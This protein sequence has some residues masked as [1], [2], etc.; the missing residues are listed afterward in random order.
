MLLSVVLPVRNGATYI[1][2]SITSILAQT[3]AEFE[4]IVV[5][6]A[7]TDTTVSIV[8]SFRDRRIRLIREPR[9]GG[10]SAFNSGV[11]VARGRY[12][13][14][15]DAD[16]V[17]S[18]TRFARQLRYLDSRKELGILGGQALRIDESGSIV[19]R[20][21]VPLTTGA[22]RL[23]SHY[24][25]PMVHPTIVF[26]RDVWTK[27]GG[28]REFAPA[29]DYDF[30]L[31]ALEHSVPVANLPFVLLE[32]RIHSQSVVHMNRQRSVMHTLAVRKMSRLRRR[33]HFADEHALLARL[34]TTEVRQS[35]WFRSLDRCIHRLRL[36]RNKSAFRGVHSGYTKLHNMAIAAASTLHPQMIQSLSAAY[37]AKRIA[38]VYEKRCSAEFDECSAPHLAP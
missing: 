19:G 21:D 8:S 7:S 12:V 17:A 1:A 32:Y 5:D 6:N 13:A 23:A 26:R 35:V 28:Y 22:I 9:L 31:R 18:P 37:R 36:R 29:A 2:S 33:G 11:R 38:Y 25:Y 10:P 24:A 20:S 16:D 4:L 3:W 34:Q 30:L 27:L 15:M 14:R